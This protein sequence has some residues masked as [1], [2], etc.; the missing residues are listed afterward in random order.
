[1]LTPFQQGKSNP[2]CSLQGQQET[3][4]GFPRVSG[5]FSHLPL[6]C[7]ESM[8]ERITDGFVNALFTLR[9]KKYCN[10]SVHPLL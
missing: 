9:E 10:L 1:M 2:P 4:P 5:K 7:L 6:N 3:P 8:P